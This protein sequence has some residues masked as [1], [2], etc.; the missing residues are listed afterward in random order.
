MTIFTGVILS[1]EVAAPTTSKD[2]P[3]LEAENPRLN[4]TDH[5]FATALLYPGVFT[6]LRN[7]PKCAVTATARAAT[8]STGNRYVGSDASFLLAR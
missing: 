2:L 6:P 8:N 3:L 5:S 1:S 7:P 4:G